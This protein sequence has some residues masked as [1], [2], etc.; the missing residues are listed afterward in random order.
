MKMEMALHG[1]AKQ[2][3]APGVSYHPLSAPA[4]SY[5]NFSTYMRLARVHFSKAYNFHSPHMIQQTPFSPPA[6]QADYASE[7]RMRQPIIKN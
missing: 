3:F 5:R 7:N 4:I 1:G 2:E 6:I